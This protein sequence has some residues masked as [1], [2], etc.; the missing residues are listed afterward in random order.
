[1]VEYIW[2]A[3]FLLSFLLLF[4]SYVLFPA[5][6]IRLGHLIKEWDNST[7]LPRVAILMAVY[8]EEAI[9]ESKLDSLLH[10]NYPLDK[11]EIFVGSDASTDR[12]NEILRYYAQK[13]PK[14]K[15]EI[16]HNRTGKP[17][18]INNLRKK[19]NAGIL[20]LTDADAIFDKNTLNN[21][22]AP[23]GDPNV[24]GV[25]ANVLGRVNPQEHVSAQEINYTRR[26]F[27][28]KKGES[29]KGAIIGAFGACY[30]IRSE[31]YKNVPRGFNVDD[32]FI[33]MN[34]LASG[35]KTVIAPK[36]NCR[37]ILSGKSKV[38]FR[39]KTRISMGNFQNLYH[40]RDFIN[41]FLNFASFAFFSHKVIRWTGPFLMILMLMANIF[42]IPGSTFFSWVFYGQVFFYFLAGIDEVLKIRGINFMPLR[43]VNHFVLMNIALLIGFFRVMTLKSDGTWDNREK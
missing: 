31:L 23:F 17:E 13:H 43:S 4:H 35:Y 28:I 30:A 10:T 11:L 9:L 12:T 1:M 29:V 34:I 27:L 37:L 26:E 41:P 38:Q 25:Q 14:I 19:V 3:V 21:L 22:V 40:F 36:A 18:I 24:G 20:V 42:L 15:Y 32:F 2:M 5:L 33:F 7:E 8:N 39:R 16:F 6:M